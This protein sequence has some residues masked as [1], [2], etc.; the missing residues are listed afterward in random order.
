MRVRRL[1]L[2]HFSQRYVDTFRFLDEAAEVF[3]GDIV[4]AEDLARVPVPR[5][6]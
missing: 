5:R 1:V 3:A 6:S 2:T 4:I